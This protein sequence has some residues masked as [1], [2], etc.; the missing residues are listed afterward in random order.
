MIIDLY[1]KDMKSL[2]AVTSWNWEFTL[3]N[4]WKSLGK[5]IPDN[6]INLYCEWSIVNYGLIL[7]EECVYVFPQLL[8]EEKDMTQGQFWNHIIGC[9]ILVLGKNICKHIT[10]QTNY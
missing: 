8:C 6:K 2:N 7:W 3:D 4:L 5:K 9:K 10:V 1:F